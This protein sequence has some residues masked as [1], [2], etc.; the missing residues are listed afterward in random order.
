MTIKKDK[1]I[2]LIK[3]IKDND[4]LEY[5]V[6]INYITINSIYFYEFISFIKNDKFI[7]YKI[8]VMLNINYDF[9]L[10]TLN[11]IETTFLKNNHK[12]DYSHE[13]YLIIIY[14]LLNNHDQWS[15]LKLDILANNP[16]K[17][18]YKTIH[19]KFI[20]YSEK[21]VFKNTFYNT[22]V[23]NDFISNNNNLL[24][25]ASMMS[26]KMGSENVSINCEYTK[27]NCTKL[28]FISNTDKIIL[29]VT[30]YDINNKEIDYDDINF[31]KKQK[32]ELKKNKKNKKNKIKKLIIEN[33][34]LRK[35]LKNKVLSKN[36]IEN[37][38]ENKI[39]NNLIIENKELINKVSLKNK[40]ENKN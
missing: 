6:F 34:E 10:Q 14:Q 19:K 26:N 27:K 31:I 8:I 35:K 15:T 40:I 38:I 39:E 32:K 20:L 1:L 9:F 33:K 21:N 13:Y 4:K 25:D 23:N 12:Q 30:P 5:S 22:T 7:L 3:L 36:E 11:T 18:H 24:I 37:K 29:S 17:Y 16:N 2:N 28:S